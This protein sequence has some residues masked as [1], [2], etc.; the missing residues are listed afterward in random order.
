L[1]QAFSAFRP[2]AASAADV[3]V[4]G[5]RSI[6]AGIGTLLRPIATPLTLGGFDA[7]VIDPVTSILR[8]QG[9]APVMA[10]GQASP[11]ADRRAAPLRPATRLG[12]R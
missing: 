1:R 9:F 6:D 2:F 4:L 11:P 10:G 7:S 5:D 12:S 3:Q 8:D